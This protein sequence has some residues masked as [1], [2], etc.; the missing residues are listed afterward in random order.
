MG[1]SAYGIGMT[2]GVLRLLALLSMGLV[3]FA[4]ISLARPSSRTQFGL[5]KY[6]SLYMLGS[7]ALL[8][9]VGL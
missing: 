7:M 6:A 3:A 2:W 4:I 5:F 8:A 1:I 9:V